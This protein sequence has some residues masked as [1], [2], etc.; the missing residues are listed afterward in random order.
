M[1]KLLL[2]LTAVICFSLL[3]VAMADPMTGCSIRILFE[4]Y[5]EAVPFCQEACNLNDGNGCHNLGWLY[6]HGL[7][8]KQDYK[9]AKTYFEK[10]C[11]LNE[12][13]GCHN[14][15]WLYDYGQ[16]VRQNFQ[17]AKEYYGKACDLGNQDGCDIYRELNQKGY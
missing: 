14:L 4:Q 17:T 7:G 9:Q 15:G 13:N 3:N 8:V 5:R 10:A 11:N 16:G 2:C 1:K 12:G 6:V